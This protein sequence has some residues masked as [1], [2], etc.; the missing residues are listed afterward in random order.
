MRKKGFTLIEV[1]VVIAIIGILSSVVF[2]AVGSQRE[3]ARIAAGKKFDA[4]LKH[5]IGSEMLGWWPLDECSGTVAKDASGFAVPA[6]LTGAVTWDTDTPFGSGCSLAFAAS[7]YTTAGGAGGNLA[8]PLGGARTFSA[9]FRSNGANGANQTILW[10][11]GCGIGWYILLYANGRAGGNFSTGTGCS[12]LTNDA[13][14][15]YESFMDG[16]WHFIA[17]GIDRI[18]GKLTLYVDGK[19]VATNTANT[20]GNAVD[21]SSFKIGNQWDFTSYF[22]GS[23]DDAR[24]YGTSL[25]VAEIEKLYAEGYAR[26]LARRL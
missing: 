19:V 11:H 17:F 18:N 12:G 2:A 16:R 25:G 13:V 14:T 15:S 24:A 20:T 8:V 21:S 6:T 7:S 23:I 1:L 26:H 4:E 3:A 22:N 9:W 10:K 5:S